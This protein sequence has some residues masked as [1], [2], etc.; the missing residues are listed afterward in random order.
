MAKFTSAKSHAA[1]QTAKFAALVLSCCIGFS[2]PEGAKANDT[3]IVA[4]GEHLSSQCVT[5]HQPSGADNGIPSI[6]GWEQQ[7][8]IQAVAEYRSKSR[9]N[10]VM[11]SIAQGLS[12]QE[13]K[14]LAAYFGSLKSKNDRVTRTE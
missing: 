11:Q 8:F 13:I 12:D 9:N 1:A 2:L 7:S 10:E 6:I 4:Y 14:A 5:C 3:D